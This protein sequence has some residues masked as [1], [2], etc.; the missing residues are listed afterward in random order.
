[1]DLAIFKV[2]FVSWF[3]VA[4]LSSV[5]D[6]LYLPSFNL[7]CVLS[8]EFQISCISV[9][10]C[11][12][13]SI[14]YLCLAFMISIIFL[15]TCLSLSVSAWM[16]FIVIIITSC[17]SEIV[18]FLLHVLFVFS[19]LLLSFQRVPFVRFHVL[20]FLLLTCVGCLWL[21][22]TSSSCHFLFPFIFFSVSVLVYMLDNLIIDV[23]AFLWDVC[24]SRYLLDICSSWSLCLSL[25][26]TFSIY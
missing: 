24:S 25:E 16:S 3:P 7:L 8:M 20:L 23:E 26:Y 1:M 18:F 10:V 17:T 5:S 15:S 13:D 4:F 19:L 12:I 22:F 11:F 6:I 9:W 14:S 21:Y 2:S